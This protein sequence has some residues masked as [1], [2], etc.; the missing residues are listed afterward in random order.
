MNASSSAIMPRCLATVPLLRNTSKITS[1][2]T[3]ES[4]TV[5]VEAH[6]ALAPVVAS[7][8]LRSCTNASIQSVHGCS[9]SSS[10]FAGLSER[11]MSDSTANARL[12]CGDALSSSSSRRSASGNTRSA[13]SSLASAAGPAALSA[14][15]L[16]DVR[17]TCG[18][19]NAMRSSVSH[20]S[21]VTGNGA[22]KSHIASKPAIL[23][24]AARCVAG[25]CARTTPMMRSTAS[26]MRSDGRSRN[27]TSRLRSHAPLNASTTVPLRSRCRR[28]RSHRSAL[29]S[30]NWRFSCVTNAS[31]MPTSSALKSGS[32]RSMSLSSVGLSL[33][34][35]W[36]ISSITALRPKTSRARCSRP[37]W[38][39]RW[40][41]VRRKCFCACS[42]AT[43]SRSNSSTSPSGYRTVRSRLPWSIA[44]PSRTSNTVAGIS[45]ARESRM[46]Y[47]TTKP[48]R[49]TNSLALRE[50]HLSACTSTVSPSIH[51]GPRTRSSSK[52]RDTPPTRSRWSASPVVRCTCVLPSSVKRKSG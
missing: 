23:A 1:F 51:A 18:L 5:L 44:S 40:I 26:R 13:E 22:R 3:I 21:A 48:W 37:W 35:R 45:G 17:G 46:W 4:S 42:S 49:E 27:E 41:S 30:A 29:T 34:G 6:I 43:G 33:S 11:L 2:C 15:A 14:D 36:T 47:S 10:M 31:S 39:L 32:I 16:T 24:I 50:C 25:D 52:R 12:C 9:H 7:S 28:S 20:R 38:S 8:A 19:A